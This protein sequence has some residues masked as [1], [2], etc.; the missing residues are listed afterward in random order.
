MPCRV[1]S[2]A[3]VLT[4]AAGQSG[5]TPLRWAVNFGNFTV[6]EELLRKG[7]NVNVEDMVCETPTSKPGH[8]RAWEGSFSVSL[9]LSPPPPSLSL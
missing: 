6:I 1:P 3:L 2:A 7:A 5:Y 4:L 8:A 9:S